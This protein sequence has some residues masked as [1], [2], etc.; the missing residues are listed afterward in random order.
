MIFASRSSV[1]RAVLKGAAGAVVAMAAMV[2]Q[3]Q[4]LE[5]RQYSNLPVGLNFVVVGYVYST[6]GLVT[7]PTLK[8]DDAKLHVHTGVLAFSR[9]IDLWGRSGRIEA[10]VPWSS[11][12]GT[13]TANGQPITRDIDGFND[14]KFRFAY[15]FYGAPALTPAEFAKAEQDVVL[16]AS[17]AVSAP[18]G[19]YDGSRVVNLGN[20]RWAFKPEV[21]GSKRMGPVTVDGALGVIFYT[22]NDDYTGGKTLDQDP[23]YVAQ[24][25][26]TYDFGRGVWISLGYTYYMGGKMIVNGVAADASLSNSRTGITFSFPIDRAQSI[27]LSASRG[28]SVRTGTDFNAVGV[29]WQ[30]RWAD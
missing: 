21:G 15:N 27:K 26:L 30:Y 6:G 4:E 25:N 7:S 9:S 29:S 24:S 28:I 17:F 18:T 12:H 20:N 8:I 1:A 14:A 2:A 3:A 16:G 23:V 5:P 19:Q 22:R 11:L 13:A 10:A